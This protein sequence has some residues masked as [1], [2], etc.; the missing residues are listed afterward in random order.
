VRE[1]RDD[2]F[3]RRSADRH[4]DKSLRRSSVWFQTVAKTETRTAPRAI[5]VRLRNGSQNATFFQK[6]WVDR[7]LSLPKYL[8]GATKLE[9]A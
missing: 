9:G 7:A 3:A 4:G 8:V 5:N 2:G 1:R 6:E